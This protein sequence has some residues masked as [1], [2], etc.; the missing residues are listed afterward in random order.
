M[1]FEPERLGLPAQGGALG[2]E[3]GA[4]TTLKGSFIVAARTI[5]NGP[6]RAEWFADSHSQALRPGLA[7]SAFQAENQQAGFDFQPTDSHSLAS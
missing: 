5:A 4:N 1:V 3:R 2:F 7:E 6:F